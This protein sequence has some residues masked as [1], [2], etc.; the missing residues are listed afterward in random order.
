[1]KIALAVIAVPVAVLGARYGWAIRAW[2]RNG[3]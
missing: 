2:F 1:M 3:R